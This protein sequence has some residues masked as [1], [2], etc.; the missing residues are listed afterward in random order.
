M[1]SGPDTALAD[2]AARGSTLVSRQPSSAPKY[3][4]RVA[5]RVVLL[6]ASAMRSGRRAASSTP[7]P[8]TFSDTNCNGS[9][10]ER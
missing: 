7:R 9:A 5:A 1:M 3:A 4:R 10:S 8:M 6:R 2:I